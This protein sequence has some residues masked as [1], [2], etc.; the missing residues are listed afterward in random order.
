M[1]KSEVSTYRVEKS[2]SFYVLKLA[3]KKDTFQV[4][5][6]KR[7]ENLLLKAKDIQGI[8]QLVD[9]Y[10]FSSKPSKS[11]W[12][13]GILKEYAKGNIIS[14]K[15]FVSDVYLKNQLEDTIHQLH[16][17]GIVNLDVVRRNIVIHPAKECIT[18]IDIGTGKEASEIS[19]KKFK[20]YCGKDWERFDSLMD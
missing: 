8:T 2:G 16:G 13:Y 15:E 4:E 14:Q 11:P 1:G 17:L 3:N 5:L 6:L 20:I 18:H 7:E 9:A 10:D 19:K 12:G